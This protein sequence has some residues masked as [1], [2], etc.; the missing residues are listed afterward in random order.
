MKVTTDACLLGAW[1]AEEIK[2]QKSKTKTFLDIGTGTGLL[3]LMLAQ[4]I[5]EANIDSIEIDKDSFEQAAENHQQTEEAALHDAD[6]AVEGKYYGHH[7]IGTAFL[8][9]ER[10][11]DSQHKQ[12]SASPSKNDRAQILGTPVFLEDVQQNFIHHRNCQD[13]AYGVAR[14][15]CVEVAF[16]RE[17]T[18]GEKQEGRRQS[19]EGDVGKETR[20]DWMQL[21]T[22]HA[23][24][25]GDFQNWS[26]HPT[27]IHYPIHC[28][29]GPGGEK[30]TSPSTGRATSFLGGQALLYVQGLRLIGSA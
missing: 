21:A 19:L 28:L 2:S 3:S 26:H 30:H 14:P 27:Q 29:A 1:V 5:K 13:H 7:S 25:Q 9:G 24:E 11:H 20:E 23:S 17:I 22:D 6:A 8:S 16:F 18:V 12:E 4:K 10:G 15:V